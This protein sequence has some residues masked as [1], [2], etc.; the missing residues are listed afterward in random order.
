MN[1]PFRVIAHHCRVIN[2]KAVLE[3]Y[4]SRKGTWTMLVTDPSG[5]TCI[6]AAGDA[7]DEAPMLAQRTG[8]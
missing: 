1:G 2:E 7:W 6:L 5:I 8:I 4:L 3:V